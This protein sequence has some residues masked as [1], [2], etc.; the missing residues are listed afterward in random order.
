MTPEQTNE[1]SPEPVRPFAVPC[2]DLDR[3]APLRWLRLGWADF[4]RAPAPT[5]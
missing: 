5:T 3:G 4:R 2:A 1:P